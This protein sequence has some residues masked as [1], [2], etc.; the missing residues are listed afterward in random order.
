MSA[1]PANGTNCPVFFILG[2]GRSGTTLLSRI[3]SAHPNI[4]VAPEGFF[5]LNLYTAYKNAT[6]HNKTIEAFCR[7]VL[8]ENRMKTWQLPV[9]LIRERLLANKEQLNYPMACRIVY[10]AYAE[11]N[12]KQIIW[13]GDKNPHYALFPQK[14]LQ[15]FPDAPVIYIYRDY[16]DNILSYRNVPFDLQDYAALAYR[17]NIYN[18]QLMKLRH[19]DHKETLYSQR[20]ED[21]LQNPEAEVSGICKFLN[22]SY[23]PEMLNFYQ[24]EETNFY[25]AGSPWFSKLNNPLNPDEKEKWKSLPESTLN[26]IDSICNETARELGYQPATY[27]RLSISN[28]LRKLSGK[29]KAYLATKAEKLIFF[30]LPLRLKVYI[31]NKYRGSTNRV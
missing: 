31:V 26:L 14:L 13:T 24:E 5:L 6:W 3:L 8:L 27:N 12:E 17:W 15:I 22:V 28:R 20:F 11:K 4:T 10:A 25:G 19:S 2:R 18:R 9:S 7:D 21:L 23:Y 1:N 16:R 30:Q 29:I